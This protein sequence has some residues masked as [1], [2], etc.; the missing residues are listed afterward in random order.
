MQELLSSRRVLVCLGAGGVGKTSVAAAL[1]IAAARTGKRVVAL[2]VDPAPRLAQSLGVS[3]D[4]DEP[5]PIASRALQQLGAPHGSLSVVILDAQKAWHDLIAKVTSDRALQQRI[6]NHAL[7]QALTQHLAGANEYMAME[8]LLTLLE[9]D[10]ADAARADLIVLDTPPSRHAL[11]FLQAPERLVE[12]LDGPILRGLASG[13]GSDAPIG[14][15]WF[16]LRVLSAVR[17][18]GRLLG[19]GMLEQL[20]ELIGELN[21]AAGGFKGRATRVSQAFRS[22]SFAYV[23]VTRATQRASHDA[24]QFECELDKLGLS[25]DAIVINRLYPALNVDLAEQTRALA[26]AV[27]PELLAKIT[28]AAEEYSQ[29]V[30]AQVENLDRLQTSASAREHRILGLPAVSGGVSALDDLALLAD[31]LTGRRDLALP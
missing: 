27:S 1:A 12:A 30:Q 31:Y 29:S 8:K 22:K 26:S 18:L 28:R 6:F 3:K 17:G 23:L 19:A 4:T 5:Q 24:L 25:A 15:R 16:S 14:L 11:E 2:T 9:A 20:A 10:S 13:L 7:Y 21:Q